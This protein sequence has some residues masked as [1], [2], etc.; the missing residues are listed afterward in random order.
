VNSY[1]GMFRL[2]SEAHIPFAV[3]D[4]LDWVGKRAFDVVI[5]TDWAPAAL[6]QYA[7]SGGKILIAGA[8]PPEFEVAAVVHTDRDVKGYIRI[9]DHAAFPGLRDT[10]LLLLNGPFTSVK[11]SAA[12]DLTLVPPSMIGPPEFVHIDMHDTDVPALVTVSIGKGT[13]LW[14][15]W[16]LGAL[17][18]RLS[19]PAHAAL[20]HDIFDRLSPSR[21]I[22]TDAHPL[23]EMSLMR[24]QGRILLHLIN[25][26]GHSETGYFPPVP[27]SSIHIRLAG[28]FHSARTVRSPGALPVKSASGY[29]E[30]TLPRLGDYELI[31][32][33]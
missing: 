21:Q 10:D 18:Y 17:Y 25:L 26:S 30:I 15:P 8:T 12:S 16:N 24:Q 11:S 32:L 19:M 1:R 6:R 22:V 9:R 4:N 5:A 2:L 28:E 7:E 13:V 27:M 20:F 33:N 23:V 3:S 31:V 14:I 29:T